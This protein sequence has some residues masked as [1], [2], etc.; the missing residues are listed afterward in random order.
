MQTSLVN[1]SLGFVVTEQP[2]D[3]EAARLRS[4]RE[5]SSVQLVRQA[6]LTRKRET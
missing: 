3:A 1:G 5:S 2:R 6:R 4:E